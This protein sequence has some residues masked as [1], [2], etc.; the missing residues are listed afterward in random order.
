[1][2]LHLLIQQ[3][4]Y[5]NNIHSIKLVIL[6]MIGLYRLYIILLYMIQLL[7]L[8]FNTIKIKALVSHSQIF[9]TQIPL[10]D[11]SIHLWVQKT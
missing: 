9:I 2:L 11:M 3:T 7:D 1:M 10:I 5:Q 6:Y 4:E 8:G